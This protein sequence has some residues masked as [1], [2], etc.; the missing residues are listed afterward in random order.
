MHRRKIQTWI[1]V[2]FDVLSIV[3]SYTNFGNSMCAILKY[4]SFSPVQSNLKLAQ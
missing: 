4:S 2:D 1:S 3:V